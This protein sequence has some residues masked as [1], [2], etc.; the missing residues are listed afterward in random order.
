[1]ERTRSREEETGCPGDTKK[2]EWGEGKEGKS[3]SQTTFGGRR[4]D[5]KEEYEKRKREER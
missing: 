1:V 4:I 2:E 3:G 5:R